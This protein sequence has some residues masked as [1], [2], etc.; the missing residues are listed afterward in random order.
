MKIKVK[1]LVEGLKP[2]EQT[3]NGD[4]IDLRCAETVHLQAFNSSL[5][6][7]KTVKQ[8]KAELE[9]NKRQLQSFLQGVDNPTA[10]EGIPKRNLES[11]TVKIA[12]IED[13][14]GSLSPNTVLLPLGVAIEL[15]KGYEAHVVPR[16]S[17]FKNFGI[18]Q[19]NSCGIID[20]IF[21]GDTDAWFMPVIALKNTVIRKND[22][23]C[24]FRILECQP[25]LD[26]EVVEFLGNK[27]RGGHGSTGVL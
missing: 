27:D 22:R 4:W 21:C 12:S 7:E 10:L 8:L 24:Q 3:A 15:P 14:I 17:T 5:E 25:K 20:S 23:I 6:I 9:F 2:I 19:T 16:S 11:I 13:Q 18:I 26:I 1:Y